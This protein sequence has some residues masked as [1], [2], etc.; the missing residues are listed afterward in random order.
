MF[1]SGGHSLSGAFDPA[2]IGLGSRLGREDH[3]WKKEESMS[4]SRSSLRSKMVKI[5]GSEGYVEENIYFAEVV[6][7]GGGVL[8]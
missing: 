5:E 8:L 1:T 2:M 4:S 6:P 7:F 3:S